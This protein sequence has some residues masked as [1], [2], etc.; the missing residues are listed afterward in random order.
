MNKNESIKNFL[1]PK[2]DDDIKKDLYKLPKNEILKKSINY[3]FIP[4]I[5]DVLNSKVDDSIIRILKNHILNADEK[6]LSYL[7]NEKILKKH[8]DKNYI[9]LIEKYILGKHEGKT[10]NYERWFYKQMNKNKQNHYNKLIFYE[11]DIYDTYMYYDNVDTFYINNNLLQ[12]FYNVFDLN[13]PLVKFLIQKM[14]SEKLGKNIEI[15][16]LKILKEPLMGEGSD[17]SF[18]NKIK[19][20]KDYLLG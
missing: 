6:T 17:K 10:K 1:K 13:Y 5:V 9:Y 18:K 8:L 2:T 3:N 11:D 15:D 7:I 4:G 20:Y 12:I 16:N 14:L 19:S